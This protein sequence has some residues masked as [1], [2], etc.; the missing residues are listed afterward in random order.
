M[1]PSRFLRHGRA[2]ALAPSIGRSLTPCERQ[3][4]A[5]L[6]AA[7]ALTVSKC[8]AAFADAALAQRSG[9]LIARSGALKLKRSIGSALAAGSISATPTPISLRMQ[10]SAA[11]SV[12]DGRFL[13]SN[14]LM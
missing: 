11:L 5:Q 7:N 1:L 8:A 6:I 14:M 3:R 10:P 4:W 12:N 9:G 13:Q 2:N